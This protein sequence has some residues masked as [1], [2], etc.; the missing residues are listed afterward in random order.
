[1]K[2]CFKCGQSLPRSEFY[3]HSEM[4]DGLLGKCKSCTR[5]DVCNHR[6]E[7]IERIRRYDID[8]SMLPHRVKARASYHEKYSQLFP[9]RIK[10]TYAVNWAVRSG[11]LA[12]EPCSVCGNARSQAHHGDYSKPLEVVWLCKPHH[13]IADEE[14][15]NRELAVVFNGRPAR[16]RFR[17]LRLSDAFTW[18][19]TRTE[20]AV[21]Q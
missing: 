17:G 10:A 8:R 2:T 5:R 9:D 4:G 12:K 6:A 3:K 14:R 7:N 1:M 19:F 11:R 16:R 20:A 15:R 18:N 21:S 13:W